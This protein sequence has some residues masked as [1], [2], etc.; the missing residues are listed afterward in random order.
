[1]KNL[2][3]MKNLNM[4]VLITSLKQQ[5]SLFFVASISILF[6]NLMAGCG[7]VPT[8]NQESELE[9]KRV[10]FELIEMISLDSIRVWMND[11]PM[12]Q[13]DF[14][15]IILPILWFKNEPREGDP[16]GSTFSRSPNATQDG[17][18]TREEHFGHRWLLNAQIIEQNVQLPDNNDGL[19][20]GRYIAK[21]HQ[22]QFRSGKTLYV[23]ISP[24]GEEYIRISRDA[25]RTTEIPIIP[26]SWKIEERIIDYNLTLDLPNPTLNIR[27]ENNQDSF[28]G[29][30]TF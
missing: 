15:A 23:L 29:P 19:L 10:G 22:V 1:M 24:D 11:E 26:D 30:V 17:E 2:K 25:N 7:N 27:A 18:F 14:D 12:S 8:S 4:K 9:N 6:I 21:Y 20:N 16:D 28:Q 13:E 3:W 5:Y